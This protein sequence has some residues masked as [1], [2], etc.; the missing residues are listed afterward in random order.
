MMS[1]GE[2]LNA[3][4]D[5]AGISGLDLSL[6]IRIFILSGFFIWAAWTVIELFKFHKT[7]TNENI[8]S[9]LSNFIQ[10]FFLVTV[11]IALVF[12]K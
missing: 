3:F 1:G 7:K 2:A 12:I 5:A 8:S 9:L 6:L 10:L 4:N 11:V